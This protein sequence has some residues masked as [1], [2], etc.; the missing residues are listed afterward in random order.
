MKRWFVSYSERRLMEIEI[1]AKD[2]DEAM[3]LVEE[4]NVDFDTAKEIDAEITS[5]NN[6][7]LSYEDDEPEDDGNENS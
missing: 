4:G 2:E 6:V 1:E 7:E 3:A 5:V